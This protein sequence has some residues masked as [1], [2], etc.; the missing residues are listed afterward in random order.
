MDTLI[1]QNT[2]YF[3]ICR[4]DYI[5]YSKDAYISIALLAQIHNLY[6]II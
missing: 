1:N 6:G 5:Y 3:L 2:V 4:Q